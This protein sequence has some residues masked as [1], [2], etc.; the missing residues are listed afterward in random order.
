MALGWLGQGHESLLAERLAAL[1]EGRSSRQHRARASP[2][3]PLRRVP[4]EKP[5]KI[6][7]NNHPAVQSS[8][9]AETKSSA[10]NI[11]NSAIRALRPFAKSAFRFIARLHE[12]CTQGVYSRPPTSENLAS[13]HFGE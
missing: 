3:C 7:M 9:P 8:V 12:N 10:A 4:S 6:A 13:T 2:R 1:E 5:K 11:A